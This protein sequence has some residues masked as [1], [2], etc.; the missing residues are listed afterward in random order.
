MKMKIFA[1]L[2]AATMLPLAANAQTVTN[3]IGSDTANVVFN[4]EV[5]PESCA[6]NI[7]P[8]TVTLAA[9]YVGQYAGVGTTLNATPFSVSVSCER[10]QIGRALLWD[11]ALHAG[12]TPVTMNNNLANTNT[13]AAGAT[14]VS[15]QVRDVDV[16]PVEN[17]NFSNSPAKLFSGTIPIGADTAHVS[18]FD[19][20]YYQEI[21][22][23]TAGLV[24]SQATFDLVY[25]Y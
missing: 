16:S 5:L 24:T 1:A 3:P 9:T 21:A 17:I 23:V 14:G 10:E 12:S 18:N 4:G 13:S 8:Q 22:V 11:V 20:R 15:I 25:G 2:I 6:L 19:A 7:S